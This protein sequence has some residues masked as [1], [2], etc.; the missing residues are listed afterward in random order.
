MI[1]RVPELP[2]D[3][4]A[5]L[6]RSHGHVRSLDAF[7][8]LI[9]LSDDTLRRLEKVNRNTPRGK[10]VRPVDYHD[11][12]A[13]VAAGYIRQGDEWWMR[14]KKAF[15]WQN[16]VMQFGEAVLEPRALQ[17]ELLEPIREA[18]VIALVREIA[19]REVQKLVDAGRSFADGAKEALIERVCGEVLFRLATTGLTR[20]SDDDDPDGSIAPEQVPTRG[21]AD[22]GGA[23]GM[24]PGHL[25]TLQLACRWA[26]ELVRE[27]PEDSTPGTGVP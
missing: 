17:G 13:F 5:D 8:G 6:R 20:K 22:G 12:E 21:P 10:W 23:P 3:V 11:F 7:A 16:L 19:V 4:I 25:R 14:F 15:V 26:V 27:E 2:G 18:H 9:G 24:P 1:T